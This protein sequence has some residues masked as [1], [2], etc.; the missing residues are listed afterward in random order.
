MLQRVLHPG[1]VVTYQSPLL[2]DLGIAH[3]FTT[4]TGGVSQGPF[5]ALNLSAIPAPGPP[6]PEDRTSTAAEIDENFRRIQVA[7]QCMGYRRVLVRQVHGNSV[8]VADGR[9]A[10]NNPTA[11]AVLTAHP[12]LLAVVRVADC[13]PILLADRSGRAVGAVHAGW[14]GIVAGIVPAAVATFQRE[15]GFVGGEMVAAIGPCISREHFEVGPEV[16]T[17]FRKADL[18]KAVET[19]VH[20]RPHIDLAAAVAVQLQRAHVPAASIDRTDRCTWRDADEFFSH[21]R[22]QGVTGRQAAVIAVREEFLAGPAPKSS[23]GFN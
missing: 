1:D 15:W 6:K 9:G 13:V 5:A 20:G 8:H 19:H 21:R 11:D 17:A 14:R 23:G 18:A 7:I 4:R 2:L 10:A 12:R 3:A 22:D 16:V